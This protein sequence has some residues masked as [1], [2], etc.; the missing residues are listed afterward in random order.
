MI[1]AAKVKSKDGRSKAASAAMPSP[2][3]ERIRELEERLADMARRQ[4]EI[5]E[6]SGEADELFRKLG[7]RKEDV[8]IAK[9]R[10]EAKVDELREMTR[11]GKHSEEVGERPMLAVI[12]AKQEEALEALK[13]AEVPADEAWREASVGVLDLDDTIVFRLAGLG[14][15]TLGQLKDTDRDSLG[16]FAIPGSDLSFDELS[17]LGDVVDAYIWR[18]RAVLDSQPADREEV[19]QA[20]Q[21]A[22]SA[23]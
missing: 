4:E 2:T 1:M 5:E 22:A 10:Y 6:C 18:S 17:R 11:A 23:E 20:V 12:E 16:V 14:I 13:L 9:E 21:E 8:K 7:F 3:D 15:Q 19:A